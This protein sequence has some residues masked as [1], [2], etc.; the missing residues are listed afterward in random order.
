MKIGKFIE[1]VDKKLASVESGAKNQSTSKSMLW[2]RG[3]QLERVI[4][5]GVSCVFILLVSYFIFFYQIELVAQGRGITTIKNSD[6]VIKLPESAYIK[7][8]HVSQSAFIKKGDPLITYR[9]I[10]DEYLLKKTEEILEKSLRQKKENEDEICYLFS[11]VF[12]DAPKGEIPVSVEC[13]EKAL[14]FSAGSKY[15]SQFYNDYKK[16]KSY[17]LNSANERLKQKQNLYSKLEIL[18]KKQKALSRG[19]A[20]TVRFYDLEAEINDLNAQIISHDLLELE[21]KKKL[22]DK[23]VAFTLKR[24]E[25]VLSLKQESESLQTDIIEKTNQADLWREKKQ[26][27]VIHS[28]ITGSVLNMMDGISPNIYLDK[29]VELFVLKKEGVSKEVKARFDSRYRAHINTGSKVK[30]K[31]SAPGANYL[32]SGEIVEISSDSLQNEKSNFNSGRY[33]EVTVL[34]DQEFINSSIDLG[35]DVDVFAI[36]ERATVFDYIMSVIPLYSKLEVW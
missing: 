35:L 4:R 21:H 30:I 28:P 27:S 33:Y 6:V 2:G 34:P 23:L 25:R 12:A 32:F 31:I 15:I 20:E 7:S 26:L 13:Q 8:I 11:D 19:G 24:A 5:W 3:L 10:D 14:G 22:N 16:E 9:N 29:G 17:Y 18:Q 36:S 1:W